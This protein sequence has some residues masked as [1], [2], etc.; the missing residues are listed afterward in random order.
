MEACSLSEIAEAFDKD[1]AELGPECGIDPICS[2]TSWIIPAGVAFAPDAERRVFSGPAGHLALLQHDHPQGPVLTAFDS[3]WGFATPLIS[4]D[5]AASISAMGSALS[6]FDWHALVMS[7]LASGTELHRQLST[8]ARGTLADT[9]DRC[10]VD[11]GDG[12]DAW[13]SRR[14]ARFR[15]SLRSAVTRC[16]D[17]G[18]A[19]T[20]VSPSVAT[21]ATTIERVLR[22]E[23]H[24]WKTDAASGLV[25]TDLGKFTADLAVRFAAAGGLRVLFASVNGDDIGYVIGGTT[26]ARYR[27][28]Q[29]SFDQ[30]YR[31][32]SVG[33]AMQ[34]HNINDLC[35]VG[36]LTYDMGMYMG[37]KESYADR[38]ESTNTLVFANPQRHS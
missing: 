37:Y 27:G 22:I 7:G 25:G 15:R 23:A 21:V 36:V 5:P 16:A 32:L 20:S 18:I 11:L 33:K 10:I 13:L 1:T 24:S 17:A 31:H 29:H 6:T 30:R 3:I 28:F 38:V 26:G 4:P 19:F 9:T 8:V 35:A 14:S 2:S 34:F 12:F